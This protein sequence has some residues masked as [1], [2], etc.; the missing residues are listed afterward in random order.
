MYFTDAG[1]CFFIDH[2]WTSAPGSF[3]FSLRNHDD[4]KPF[5]APLKKDDIAAIYRA[6]ENGPDFGFDFFICNNAA[7]IL[8]SSTDF[9]KAFQLPSGYTYNQT[10]T[11]A[12]LAGSYYFSP[13]EVEVLYIKQNHTAV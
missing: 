4:L 11:K 6:R 5:K 9:G 2:S 7:S 13:A 10:N 3:L 12:L 8:Y 1:L